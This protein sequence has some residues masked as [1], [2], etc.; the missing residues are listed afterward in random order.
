M[1]MYIKLKI[2]DLF[3]TYVDSMNDPPPPKK[4]HKNKKKIDYLHLIST[5]S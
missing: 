3:H 5:F 4:K 2:Y 1:Y